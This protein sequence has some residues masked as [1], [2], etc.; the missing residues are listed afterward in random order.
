MKN[1]KNLG[2]ND[3]EGIKKVLEKMERCK[4]RLADY[5]NEK[6]QHLSTSG[7]LSLLIAFSVLYSFY[8][9]RLITRAI[10]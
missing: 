2:A 8:L 5:L 9:L 7:L 6:C 10:H 1:K 3:A 4:R